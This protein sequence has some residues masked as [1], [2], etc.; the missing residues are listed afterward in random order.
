MAGGDEIDPGEDASFAQGVGGL[1]DVG[2]GKFSWGADGVQ[3]LRIGGDA[4]A[5]IFLG[6]VIVLL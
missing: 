2:D 4:D 6:D 3:L 5:S 1:V